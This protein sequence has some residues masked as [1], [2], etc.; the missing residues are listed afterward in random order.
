MAISLL[1]V[2]LIKGT[3][4]FISG[5]FPLLEIQIITSS[6]CISPKSP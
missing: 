3:R 1:F 5:V 4:A 2:F 6:L